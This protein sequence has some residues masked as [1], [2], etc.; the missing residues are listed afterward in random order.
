MPKQKKTIYEADLEE[1]KLLIL[2]AGRGERKQIEDMLHECGLVFMSEGVTQRTLLDY[3]GDLNP[4][5]LKTWEA[6]GLPT[7]GK[8]GRAKRYPL[9]QLAYFLWQKCKPPMGRPRT[10]TTDGEASHRER[11]EE[12]RAKRAEMEFKR[13][14]GELVDR[15]EA[16]SSMVQMITEFQAMMFSLAATIGFRLQNQTASYIRNRLE[17]EIGWIF[18]RL[19]DGHVSVP[20]KIAKKLK[21]LI[22]DGFP[23]AKA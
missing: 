3:M 10:I 21:K 6:E 14:M 9:P 17:Q 5:T 2:E 4:K 16:E 8:A 20:A 15:V 12:F 19:E 11:Y 18:Q 22:S 1:M 13:D 7:N 23:P